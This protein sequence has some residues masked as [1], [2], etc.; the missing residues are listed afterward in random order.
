MCHNFF[1]H[2]SLSAHLDCF[3][4]LAT[5]NTVAIN[6][7]VH[8][9]FWIMVFSGYMPNNRISR[10]YGSF[11]KI[12]LMAQQLKNLPAV[13]ETQAMVQFLGWEASLEEEMATHSS[14]LAISTYPSAIVLTRI[15]I[16]IRKEFPFL[17]T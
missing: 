10:S 4:V 8:M 6:F 9:S 13:Q 1:I 7:G 17:L 3:H 12:S 15:Y 5:V 11:V 2:S 14:T 16:C